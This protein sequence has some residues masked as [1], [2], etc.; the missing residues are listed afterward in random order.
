MRWVRHRCALIRIELSFFYGLVTNC[1]I[2]RLLTL[3]ELS[4]RLAWSVFLTKTETVGNGI[5][6]RTHTG[7]GCSQKF[8]SLR[9]R[10][11]FVT[12]IFAKHLGNFP[13]TIMYKSD[14][15]EEVRPAAFQR[16]LSML[17]LCWWLEDHSPSLA[18]NQHVDE[19]QLFS[20]KVPYRSARRFLRAYRTLLI[21]PLKSSCLVLGNFSRP[22]TAQIY[23]SACVFLVFHCDT[24]T[25]HLLSQS[26]VSY[27]ENYAIQRAGTERYQEI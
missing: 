14:A 3:S 4:S 25:S 20:A 2:C 7:R 8:D 22:P 5:A 23:T 24:R 21:L 13:G 19:Y 27:C 26:C 11:L 16:V 18:G 10:T 15:A 17:L 1:L 9:A 6:T 12:F